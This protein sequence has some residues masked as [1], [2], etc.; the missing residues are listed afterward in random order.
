MDSFLL[1]RSEAMVGVRPTGVGQSK[2]EPL[3]IIRPNED[4]HT[5]CRVLPGSKLMS[6]DCRIRETISSSQTCAG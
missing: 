2:S 4:R 3:L 5:E 1:A 6:L